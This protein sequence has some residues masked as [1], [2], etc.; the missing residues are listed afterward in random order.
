MNDL[1]APLLLVMEDELDAF[2]CFVGLMRR[3]VRIARPSLFVRAGTNT[4]FGGFFCPSGSTL[5]T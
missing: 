1:A 4:F 2:C 3:L 5:W